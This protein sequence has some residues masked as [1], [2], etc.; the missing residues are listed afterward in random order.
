MVS[1]S[2]TTYTITARPK[3]LA[4]RTT[5][6]GSSAMYTAGRLMDWCRNRRVHQR[7]TFSLVFVQTSCPRAI[8]G[9]IRFVLIIAKGSK[10]EINM[11]DGSSTSRILAIV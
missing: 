4:F 9:A 8:D 1:G 5:A 11:R 2:S 3:A 6:S 10:E 7:P